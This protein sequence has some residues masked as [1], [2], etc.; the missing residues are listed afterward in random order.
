MGLNDSV[1]GGFDGVAFAVGA[2]VDVA[3]GVVDEPVVVTTVVVDA[4]VGVD[5]VVVAAVA[6]A[7]VIDGGVDVGDLARWSLCDASSFE[8]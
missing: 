1:A 5:V 2:V 6:G 3:V 4:A 8:R 7:D